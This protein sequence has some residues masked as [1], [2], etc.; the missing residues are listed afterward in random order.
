MLPKLWLLV[1]PKGQ[2]MPLIELSWTAKTS[3]IKSY[4]NRLFKVYSCSGSIERKYWFFNISKLN[5]LKPLRAEHQPA[6]VSLASAHFPRE[7]AAPPCPLLSRS[8]CLQVKLSISHDLQ[9]L[10]NLPSGHTW[11]TCQ[12]SILK[13]LWSHTDSIV[14]CSE[15]T[16]DIIS[17]L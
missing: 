17:F 9:L 5:P 1:F 3:D 6:P 12:L 14:Q 16:I 13:S 10:S 8:L 11:Q 2:T 15:I 4:S 7:P